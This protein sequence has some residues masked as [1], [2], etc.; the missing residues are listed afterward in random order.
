MDSNPEQKQQSFGKYILINEL[1]DKFSNAFDDEIRQLVSSIQYLEGIHFS[2]VYFPLKHLGY[3]AVINSVADLYCRNIE[4]EALSVNLGLS[5]RFTR[6]DIEALLEGLVI[7]C[8]RY[9]L[10]ISSL[11]INS[12][13][14]GMSLN[15]AAYGSKTEKPE[16]SVE[17]TDLLCVTGDLGAAFMGL[18]LLER[19][20]KVFE[21]TQ[22][23][24]PKL[25]GF[26]YVIGRQLRPDL[27][28]KVFELLKENNIIP[29]MIRTIRD[30]LA[31]EAIHIASDSGLGCRIYHNKLPIDTETGDAGKELNIEPIIAALNG[32]D[33]FEF[34]FTVPVA[35]F[36]R[37]SKVD[38]V[39][40]VGHMTG[41]G[42][43]YSLSLQD[44][45]LAELKAQGWSVE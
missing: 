38:G 18:Q 31:S 19:E 41:A 33:D 6:I 45:S 37:V 14:T 1:K 27:K 32:G 42:E 5:S 12:S 22:G 7:A 4:P 23:A 24:Q 43:G 25:E 16:S 11:D 9:G 2:L 21:E 36:D 8:E 35:E 17:Q 28:I 29:G 44:G 26:E 40:V 13:L 15:V 3:K 10:K 34:V 20:R 39:S 30:G